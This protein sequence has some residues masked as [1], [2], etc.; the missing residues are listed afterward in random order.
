MR[1]SGGRAEVTG[2]FVME[3]R[4]MWEVIITRLPWILWLLT[5]DNM[6]SLFCPFNYGRA[7]HWV[8]STLESF[9]G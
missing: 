5:E 4:G 7:A 8:N 9:S 3:T 6:F 2:D 1:V